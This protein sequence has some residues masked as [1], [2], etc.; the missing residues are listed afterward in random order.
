[1]INTSAMDIVR[2]GREGTDFTLQ[3]VLT[4]LSA[5]VITLVSARVGDMT[6]YS[7]LFTME[8]LLASLSFVF[9]LFIN[10]YHPTE[11]E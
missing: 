10:P 11:K 5:M 6:G 1:M 2:D 3:I 9:I 7:G 4:H 8:L